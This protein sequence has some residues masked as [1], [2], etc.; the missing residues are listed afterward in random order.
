MCSLLFRILYFGCMF[1]CDYTHTLGVIFYFQ[2]CL[3]YDMSYY[4]AFGILWLLLINRIVKLV[5]L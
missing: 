3:S 5:I 4:D 1:G 2:F